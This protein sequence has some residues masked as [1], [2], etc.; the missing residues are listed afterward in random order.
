MT[1]FLIAVKNILIRLLEISVIVLVAVL[2]IDVLWGVTSRELGTLVAYLTKKG[3]RPWP[4]LPTGQTEWTE[5]IAQYLLVWVSLLGASVAFGAKS[6]LGVDYFVGKLH[7]QAQKLTAVIVNILVAAF[8]VAV[9]IYGGYILVS[10]TLAA[11]QITPALQIKMGYVYLAVPI[12]GVF[13]VIF[14]IE[15]VAEIL[16]GKES[17]PEP[18]PVEREVFE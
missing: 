11:G 18:E 10:K 17:P 1:K 9:M 3:Y 13:V 16:S 8:A 6:H 5:E 4:F 15:A 7:P 12:C 14:C 2:V